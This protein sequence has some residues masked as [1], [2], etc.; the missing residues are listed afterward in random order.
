MW[1]CS[2]KLQYI[3]VVVRRHCS[4]MV[5]FIC[6]Y[7]VSEYLNSCKSSQFRSGLAW[8]VISVRC[9]CNTTSSQ[10]VERS[11]NFTSN[12]NV[13]RV[14]ITSTPVNTGCKCICLWISCHYPDNVSIYR[15]HVRCKWGLIV[16]N[17]R[18]HIMCHLPSYTQS[19]IPLKIRFSSPL[20]VICCGGDSGLVFMYTLFSQT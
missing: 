1:W 5:H 9:K 8:I 15:S 16:H 14:E 2:C 4:S 3:C 18:V 17:S 19:G 6:S 13:G 10:Q 7:W 12:H 20:K 11:P